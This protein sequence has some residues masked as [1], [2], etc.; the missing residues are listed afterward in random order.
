M[1]D[2]SETSTCPIMSFCDSAVKFH[3]NLEQ[4]VLSDK[5]QTYLKCAL[6]M[7]VIGCFGNTTQDFDTVVR[8]T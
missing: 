5:V 2:A 6:I 3:K 7:L 4:F 1:A 8:T